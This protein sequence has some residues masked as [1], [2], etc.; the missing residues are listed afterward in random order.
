MPGTVKRYDTTTI[1]AG[2]VGDLWT[3]V[4]VPAATQR[5]SL[6]TDG[7]PDATANPAAKHLGHTDA[8]TKIT[9]NMS[10]TDHFV[11]EVPYPV[12]SS[13]DQTTF[14]MSGSFTQVFD[15]EML[16][17]LTENFA[18][19]STTPSSHKSFT[20]GTPPSLAY[21]TITL[22]AP[23]PMNASK[24]FVC[25]MYSAQNVAGLDIT[26]DRKG[27]SMTPFNF[28]GYALTSR[29]ANDQLGNYWWQI[30]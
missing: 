21:R 20:I 12:I 17:A 2:S 3:G 24:F 7:T 8:G 4:A 28:R 19:Y 14:E 1:R 29:A 26:I 10:V 30:V 15:E 18:T 9:M 11:D 23:T 16:K 25:Q 6:F 22:I 5:I 13:F 27:R